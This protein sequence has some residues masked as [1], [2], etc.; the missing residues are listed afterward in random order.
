[1]AVSVGIF[2]IFT[3]V[4]IAS[5]LNFF[6]NYRTQVLLS[7]LQTAAHTMSNLI[8]SGK[9]NPS[10]WEDSGTT[11]VGLGLTSDL[12]RLRLSV[13][14]NAT[15]RNNTS[16]G[17]DITLD[18]ACTGKAWNNTLILYNSNNAPVVFDLQNEVFCASQFLKNASIVLND[19]FA[20]SITK[21]YH[22]YYSPDK[23]VTSVSYT[24]PSGYATNMTIVLFPEEKLSALSLAKLGALRKI[25]YDDIAPCVGDYD[26]YIRILN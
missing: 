13:Q 9:G 24:L 4:I 26:F 5:L 19:S 1:M 16:V 14:N 3:A 6:G 11:P 18:S 8:L 12:Y 17:V 2:V 15:A 10:N 23:N 20:P 21:Y 25:N 7:E 22:L